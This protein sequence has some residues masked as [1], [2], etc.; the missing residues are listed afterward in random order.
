MKT[1]PSTEY[2][3]LGALM[4]GA[5][6]GYEIMQFIETAMGHT[7][8]VGASQLYVLL[9]KLEQDGFLRS[10]ME[11][12]GTRPPKRVFSLR[13]AGK[14]SFLDWLHS[15]TQHVRDLRIEFL[16]KL[17]FFNR[18]SLK[19]GRDLVLAQI[20]VLEQ[21]KERI[22]Q[23]QENEKDPF[24]RLVFGFKIATVEAWLQWLIKQ[25]K[26]FIKEVQDNG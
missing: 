2:A 15:P 11:T 6:H 26:P 16:A 12:Q 10:S 25:A 3:L 19:G 1:K 5:K 9:K 14:K 8:Y 13:Q 23:R 7:W 21:T 18:L 22:E 4:A 24:N 20:Q 17:F